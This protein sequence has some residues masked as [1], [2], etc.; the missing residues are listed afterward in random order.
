MSQENNSAPV[1][2]IDLGATS[3]RVM[4]GDLVDG[5]VQLSLIHRFANGAVPLSALEAGATPG[6]LAWDIDMLWHEIRHGLKLAFGQRADISSIGVDSWAV[7]YALLKD[8]QRLGQIRHYRDPRNELAVPELEAK[9]NRTN[10]FARNGLQY[11]P[12]N[13]IYQ[14]EA[15]KLEPRLA[16]A[17]TLLLVPDYINWLL[18]GQARSEWTNLS[19]TGLLNLQANSWDEELS[20]HLGVQQILA[21]IVHPGERVGILTDRL[22]QEF[23]AI[24]E[25]SVV[26]VASHDTASA[27]AAT[28]LTSSKSAYVSC[29]TWGLVGVELSDAVLEP[30]AQAAGFTNE[31]GIDSTVRFLK[32]VTGTFLLSESIREWNESLSG[33]G[34]GLASLEELLVLAEQLPTPDVLIDPQNDSFLA[35][36]NIPDRISQAIVHAGGALPQSREALIRVVIESLAASFAAESFK[37]A[38]LGG[39][40]PDAIHLVGGGSQSNLLCQLT[41]N[42]AGVPVVA[43]PVECTALGNVLVQFRANSKDPWEKNQLR[44]IAR[45]SIELLRFEPEKVKT[46]A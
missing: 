30:E 12:F 27:V 18:T 35:P 4:L 21:P 1:V 28:P 41:S 17:D 44:D 19:T 15:E 25:V 34:E 39:F 36:G 31:L 16:N 2:A 38:E 40:E 8:G 10:L 13:T 11:L 23:G 46:V 37:A 14:L 22:A 32:N 24:G 7:D 33:N 5:K 20:D 43:G 29:G 6:A 3:G 9:F 45:N 26:A 42:I